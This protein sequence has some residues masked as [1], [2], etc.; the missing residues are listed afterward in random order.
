MKRI[1]QVLSARRETLHKL[2]NRG[3]IDRSDS[4]EGLTSRR[5]LAHMSKAVGFIVSSEEDLRGIDIPGVLS[6]EP[7]W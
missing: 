6:I 2:C 4:C 1:T 7:L 3:L 5:S